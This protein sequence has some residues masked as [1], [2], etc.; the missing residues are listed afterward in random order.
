[1]AGH[2]HPRH[3]VDIH[4][5][6]WISTPGRGHFFFFWCSRPRVLFITEWT[7]LNRIFVEQTNTHSSS[8]ERTQ[9]LLE[10][11]NRT[12]AKGWLEQDRICYQLTIDSSEIDKL[13]SQPLCPPRR[14]STLF[15]VTS[16]QP[17]DPVSDWILY[18]ALF[19]GC[20]WLSLHCYA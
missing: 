12:N 6:E 15:S 5:P 7:F 14:P 4:P 16:C 18:I 9:N 10:R 2:R 3:R 17:H 11:P 1:M 13:C 19:Y 20:M 8:E